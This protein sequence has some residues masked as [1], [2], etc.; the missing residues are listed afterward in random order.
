MAAN[1]D[2][3]GEVDRFFPNFRSS[4][5]FQ[6]FSINSQHFSISVLTFSISVI[7]LSITVLS[8]SQPTVP[9]Y[10]RSADSFQLSDH[11]PF[12]RLLPRTNTNTNTNTN[13][14]RSAN[15]FQLSDHPPFPLPPSPLPRTPILYEPAMQCVSPL[16]TAF[17]FH[18][19]H[20]LLLLPVPFSLRIF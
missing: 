9:K 12:P 2:K 3:I 7:T 14:G 17:N 18:Q 20:L 1:S 15:S 16:F 8:E 13:T 4:I 11:P 10:R 5:N 19:S 6:Y